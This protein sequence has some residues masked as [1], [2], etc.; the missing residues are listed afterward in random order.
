MLIAKFRRPALGAA[1]GIAVLLALPGTGAADEVP[2][3]KVTASKLDLTP[4]HVEAVRARSA[5]GNRVAAPQGPMAHRCRRGPKA[6]GQGG[7][8]D[9]RPLHRRSRLQRAASV[10]S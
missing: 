5:A 1:T 6:G 7:Q 8:A 2:A 3:K 10:L 4:E 9:R